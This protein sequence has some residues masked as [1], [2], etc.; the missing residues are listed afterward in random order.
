VRTRELIRDLKKVERRADLRSLGGTKTALELIHRIS[1]ILNQFFHDFDGGMNQVIDLVI[2]VTGAMRGALL[3]LDG[4]DEPEVVV[5]RS[6]ERRSLPLED[7]RIPSSL[8]DKVLSRGASVF[9]SDLADDAG[10]DLF[11]ITSALCAPL[12]YTSG[13]DALDYAERR[14]E[15]DAQVRVLGMIYVDSESISSPLSQQG[16][17]FLEAIAN[18]ATVA[19]RNARVYLEATQDSLTGLAIRRVFEGRLVEE[20]QAASKEGRPLSLLMTDLDHFKSV[21]DVFGHPVGDEVLRLAARETRT[22]VRSTDLVARYGGEEFALLL[23]NTR[24]TEALAI[25]EKIRASVAN[26]RFA[27]GR[28]RI[29]ISVGIAEVP[30]HAD[31]AEDLVNHADKALYQAKELGRNRTVVWSEAIGRQAAREDKLAGILTGDWSRDYRNVSMLLETLELINGAED[32]A[33]AIQAVVEKMVE[34][35]DADRGILL[36]GEDAEHLKVHLA[37]DKGGRRLA[38]PVHFSSSVVQRVF[39]DRSPFVIQDTVDDLGGKPTPKSV[40]D[41]DIRSVMCAP[42]KSRGQ[43]FGAIYVDSRRKAQGFLAADLSF[44]NAMASQAATVLAR[45]I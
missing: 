45:K 25:A 31:N 8:T 24:A 43:I 42:L 36:L 26:L 18:H 37:L 20:I 44:F 16:L 11:K 15:G 14:L 38:R 4:Q 41:L 35:S 3:L 10:E 6:I 28:G 30:A 39:A 9:L 27:R 40:I 12:L 21:N 33:G 5:A 29:T 32:L 1:D 17:Y 7:M 13:G 34:I 2:E 22:A 19:L 23:P